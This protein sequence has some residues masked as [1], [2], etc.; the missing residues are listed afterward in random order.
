VKLR[1]GLDEDRFTF[2]EAARIA[3]EE[4]CAA[5]GLH[6]RTVAQLYSGR[7]RWEFIRELKGL[8]GIPVIGNGDIFQA[9]DAAALIEATG[10]DGVIIGR[11]CLGNPWL[12]RDLKRLFA[13]EAAPMPPT[14]E[15]HIG[16]IRLHYDLLRE[17]CT[18]PQAADMLMRKFGTWYARGLRNAAAIRRRFQTIEGPQDLEGILEEMARC[19]WEHGFRPFAPGE[20][21]RPGTCGG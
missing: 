12:F 4:G 9:S 16:I 3:E 15:E 7:A 19:G 17:H 13:G 10:C 18:R 2:R 21:G 20:A 6:A 1:L 11:G 8:V 14:L 5:V